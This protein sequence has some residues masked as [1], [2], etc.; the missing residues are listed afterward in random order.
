MTA[1]SNRAIFFRLALD[2][3]PMVSYHYRSRGWALNAD[4]AQGSPAYRLQPFCVDS[5]MYRRR[6]LIFIRLNIMLPSRTYGSTKSLER[7][8]RYTTWPKMPDFYFGYAVL[9][10]HQPGRSSRRNPDRQRITP[11][12]VRDF[13]T[14]NA[15]F[16]NKHRRTRHLR[17]LRCSP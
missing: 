3:Q 10:I 2:H 6:R 8:P 4:A 1:G 9:V 13:G 16:G 15:G 14:C 11:C 17:L 12:E 7:C 5:E